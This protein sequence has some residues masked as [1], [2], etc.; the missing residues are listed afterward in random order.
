MDENIKEKI[1]S[2]QAYNKKILEELSA[3]VEE[4]P[5]L[6]LGQIL[7]SK[8]ILQ[9]ERDIFYDESVDIFNRMN[10]NET[11]YRQIQVNDA[12]PANKFDGKV[13]EGVAMTK[14]RVQDENAF[15]MTFKD[16]TFIALCVAE[17]TLYNVCAL[18][19]ARFGTAASYVGTKIDVSEKGLSENNFISALERLKIIDVGDDSVM[20][21]AKQV[22]NETYSKKYDEYIKLKKIFEN[23]DRQTD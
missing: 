22:L 3:A 19:N 14:S 9:C 6:R 2:R 13:V 11:P 21:A 5:E 18:K 15:I 20:D 17:D 7:Y 8:N 10:K 12:T 1:E 16:G 23:E 4:H